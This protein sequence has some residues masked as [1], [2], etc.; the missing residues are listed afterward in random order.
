MTISSYRFLI[1]TIIKHHNNHTCRKML[2]LKRVDP[3]LQT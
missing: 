2:I 1:I 3:T